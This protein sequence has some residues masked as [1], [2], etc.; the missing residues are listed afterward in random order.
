Q[1]RKGQYEFVFATDGESAL[2]ELRRHG[3]IDVAMTDINMP[4]MDGLTFLK[5]VG[6]V[7]PILKVIM[8]SAYSDM[9]NIREAMNRGAFDFLVKPIDFKDLE[10]TIDK[11]LKHVRALRKT[12]RSTEEN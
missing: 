3:D 1:I 5:H 9:T 7:D 6:E 12:L 10:I 4:G 2:A 8:V 11:T